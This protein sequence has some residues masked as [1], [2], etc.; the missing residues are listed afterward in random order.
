MQLQAASTGLS[1]QAITET[2]ANT[3]R[4]RPNLPH[5]ALESYIGSGTMSL[6]GDG[7]THIAFLLSY[8]TPKGTW[9]MVLAVLPL[10]TG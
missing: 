1:M 8:A 7:S 10:Q 5:C 9:F 4:R 2:D 3:A 6:I